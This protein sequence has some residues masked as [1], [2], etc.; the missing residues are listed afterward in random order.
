M[1]SDLKGRALDALEGKWGLERG[2]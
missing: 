2:K 1:I